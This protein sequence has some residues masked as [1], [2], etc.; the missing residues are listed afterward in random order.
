MALGRID[1]CLDHVLGSG[2]DRFLYKIISYSNMS[3]IITA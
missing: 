3:K 2:L 1:R